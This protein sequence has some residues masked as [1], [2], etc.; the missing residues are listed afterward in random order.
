MSILA[1]IRED[2][3]QAM[4]DHDNLTRDTLR[5][6]AGAIRQ[7]EIDER[8]EL[9]DAETEK[10]LQKQIK[11]R[12]DAIE[13]YKVG[14]RDDLVEKESGE[15]AIIERYLPKQLSDDE[16]ETTL[17]AIVASLETK[18]IGGVM[19]KAKEVIGSRA[20]GKRISAKA[21]ELLG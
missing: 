1:Q 6:I 8:K 21:K 11:L 17:K 3:K 14:K 2:T 16:L 15:V 20:D 4:R 19:A 9:S 12:L 13:Q 10:A 18:T 5:N 7:I